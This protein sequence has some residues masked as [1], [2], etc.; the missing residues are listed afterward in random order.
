MTYD[1]KFTPSAKK[2]WDK[3][4]NS[5]K[6]V[7]KKALIKRLDNPFVIASK[8]KGLP[9]D[10]YKIK[11]RTTGYRLIYTVEDNEMV[12]LVIMINKR[13]VVYEKLHKVFE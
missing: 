10:C 4:D 1:L 5:I 6:Q 12:L 8:L 3:L 13:D 7:F 11:L 2:E 9:I